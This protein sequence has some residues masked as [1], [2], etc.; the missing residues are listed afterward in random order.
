MRAPG[1][2][3]WL[4]LCICE[5]KG[6]PGTQLSFPSLALPLPK[7]VAQPSAAPSPSSARRSQV[8]GDSGPRAGQCDGRGT[9]SGATQNGDVRGTTDR[10]RPSWPGLIVTTCMKQEVLVRNSELTSHHRQEEFGKGQKE[11]GDASAHVLPA[12]QS[13]SRWN[14]SRLSDA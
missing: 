4:G 8:R 10:N 12:S 11:R 14:P 3:A 1:V 7:P 9:N 5:G 2:C 13:P 6:V